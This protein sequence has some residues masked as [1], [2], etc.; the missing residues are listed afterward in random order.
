MS[1]FQITLGPFSRGSLVLS[2]IAIAH[3]VLV[4]IIWFAGIVL[5]WPMFNARLWLIF[6]WLWTVWLLVLSWRAKHDAKLV[7]IT[8]LICV[9][10][11]L[12]SFTTIY[13]F[14]AWWIQGFAP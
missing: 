6:A 2:G 4:L 7:L 3:A 14:T 5:D 10:L 9:A 8:I 13:V 12:P 11:I 1:A